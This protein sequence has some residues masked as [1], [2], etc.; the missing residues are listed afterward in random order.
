MSLST[1]GVGDVDGNAGLGVY[2]TTLALALVWILLICLP[3]WLMA[4]GMVTLAQIGY[5]TF[6]IICHQIPERSWQI[7]GLP[8]AVCSRCTAIY[9]GAVLGLLLYPI[10]R[11]TPLLIRLTHHSRRL[12]ALGLLPMLADVAFDLS[13]I[14][15]NTFSTRAITGGI[16]GVAISLYLLPAILAIGA[17]WRQVRMINETGE[18]GNEQ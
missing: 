16:A 15:A 3:P 1:R 8:L 9:V 14:R 18:D 7:A 2:L 13:G 12:L 10:I 17:E 11:Q 6:S 5:R 4:E